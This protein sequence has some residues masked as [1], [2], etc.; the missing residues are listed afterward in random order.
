MAIGRAAFAY[1]HQNQLAHIQSHLD[2][3]LNPLLGSNPIIAPAFLPTFLEHFKQHLMLWYLGHMNGYVEESLGRP[4]KDYDTAGITGEIDKLYALA[5]QHTQ[6]DAKEAFAKVMPA[7]Q[8]I[9]QAVEK[10]KPKPEM[11]G[12][13]QVYLQTS[14]AETQRRGKRD[15]TELALDAERLKND[16]LN[17]NRE[18]QIKIAL[19][20][21]DNLTEERI[22][23]AELTQDAA[24]LKQEQ[25]QTAM[26]AQ[27]S[28]QRTLGV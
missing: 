2:F 27:E 22:K 23:T 4:V 26:A 16:T 6:M 25:E 19:N 3:A 15:A 5:S 9:L 12:S 13:D 20:A 10:L 8:Q 18:Q 28:A 21:S 11:T 7:M 14:M 1:P 17:K 24:I